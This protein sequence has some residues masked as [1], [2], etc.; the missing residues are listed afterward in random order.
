MSAKG[1]VRA[2]LST[3]LDCGRDAGSLCQSPAMKN[4][5]CRMHGGKSPGAPK[6]NKNALKHERYTAEQSQGAGRRANPYC[7]EIV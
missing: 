5:R 3:K 1:F 6:E 7:K 2:W 4:D